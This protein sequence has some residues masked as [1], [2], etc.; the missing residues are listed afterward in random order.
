[1]RGLQILIAPADY[2][3]ATKGKLAQ[4]AEPKRNIYLRNL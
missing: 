2:L 3:L 4:I 1:M